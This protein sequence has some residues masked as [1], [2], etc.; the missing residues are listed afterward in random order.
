MT[1]QIKKIHLQNWKCYDNQVIEFN[2]NTERNIWIIWGLNGYGKTSILEA[3]LWCLY[4]NEIVSPK[5]LIKAEVDL[6]EQLPEKQGYFH[7]PNV[8]HN[9]ELELSVS[10]TLQ[11]ETHNYLISRTAKRVKRGNSFYAEV[12]EASF[13]LDG[14]LKT[15]SRERIDLLLPRSCKEFFF[16]DG[17]KI[18]EY[19]SVTQTK[20]T[21]KAIESILGIPEIINLKTDSKNVLEKFEQKINQANSN[22]KKLQD[23]KTKL[24]QLKHEIAT[25]KDTL[26]TAIQEYKNELTILEDTNE[27]ANQVKEL[28]DKLYRLKELA[29]KKQTLEQQLEKIE[30][31]IT[32]VMEI[33]SIPLMSNFIKEVA[34]D[35]QIQTMTNTRISIS[36]DQLKELLEAD[37]CV[38]G[39]CIDKEASDYIVQQLKNIENS[40]I[41]QEESSRLESLRIQ[42]KS[43]SL[44]KIPNLDNLLLKRDHIEEDIEEIKQVTETLKKDT[45]GVSEMEANEIWRKVGQQERIVKEAEAT[46]QR[47]RN[48]IES[49]QQQQDELTRQRGELLN[50]DREKVVLQKQYELAEGLNKATDELIDWYTKNCQQ[51][52]ENHASRLHNLVTNKPD[53]YKGVIL[54]N[55]YNLRIKQANGDIINPES[56]S[57]G[58]KEALVFTFIAGLNLASG[59]AAPLMMDTP[60]GKLDKIHQENIVKSLPKI[61]SQVILLATDRDL[62]DHLLQQLKPNVAQIHK[63][64]RLGGIEDASVV[65]VEE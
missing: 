46:I 2:L 12:S 18:K 40:G 24:F 9:P 65:E 3:A 58:E 54:K 50:S 63:I 52:L 39:R 30:K 59:K 25:K 32:K 8:K 34:S 35:L 1:L 60:F 4:G 33:A 31:D 11:N 17:E 36:V 28:K 6:Q 5:K 38:C 10:L 44:Y 61:D 49:L 64:R 37:T 42:L 55:G 13:N 15:D 21:R 53:E 47:L 41:L 26:Q 62:P 45:Q 43:L 16:F 57:E 27:R 14:K 48:Q 19:S 56:L 22:N 51:T 23:I 20:E 29:Q 7:Y